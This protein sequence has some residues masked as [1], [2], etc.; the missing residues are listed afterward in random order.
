MIFTILLI[1]MRKIVYL[2]KLIDSK[3]NKRVVFAHLIN[4]RM[5]DC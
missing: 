2:K 3:T 4:I 1:R 5:Q